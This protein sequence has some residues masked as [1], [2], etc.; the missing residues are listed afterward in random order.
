MA[1]N[2]EL[3]VVV[4][5]DASSAQRAFRTVD[6][7]AGR[8]SN[9]VGGKFKSMALAIGGA[10]AGIQI[11]GFL[12]GAVQEARE[13]EKIGRIT[14]NTI[15]QT[16]G[17]A[18]VTAKDVDKMSEALSNQ[19]GIDDDL[20]QGGANLLLTFKNVRNEVG[21]GNDIFN[22][23]NGLA[24][25]MSVAFGQDLNSS[26]IQLGKALDNPIK[27]V[28]A[29]QRV[30][31]SFTDQQK[32]QIKTLVESGK[33][34]EAQKIILGELESQVGGTAKA[35]A[36]PW[37]KFGVVMGNLKES[38]GKSLLPILSDLATWLGERLPGA[39]ARVQQWFKD[40]KETIKAWGD[41]IGQVISFIANEVIPRLVTAFQ[42][43]FARTQEIIG[44]LQAAWRMFGDDLTRIFQ[45]VFGVIKGVWDFFAGIFTGDWS[46]VW[47]A[48]LGIFQGAWNIVAGAI[49]AAF[50]AIAGI[51]QG[52]WE[53]F[54]G[55]WEGA[56]N[57]IKDIAKKVIDTVSG[58]LTDL[59]DTAKDLLEKLGLI[60]RKKSIEQA[61]KN[62]KP[63]DPTILGPPK[64]GPLPPGGTI[65]AP[66]KKQ[67]ARGGWLFPGDVSLVG[68][69][70]PEIITARR[71]GYVHT[72]AETARMLAGNHMNL[73]D[74]AVRV[75]LIFNGSPDAATVARIR[76][77][78]DA[79][80]TSAFREAGRMQL[81]GVG[82]N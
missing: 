27:G 62:W 34:L 47:N 63:G 6:D 65:T 50:G 16:G 1:G 14:A 30:G 76:R 57:A 75:N 15:K 66:K 52:A 74:G 56:W 80:I 78:V 43:V 77:E 36:D 38:I 82:S 51:F 59:L 39:I 21:K 61:A 9:S 60:E 37:Q 73:A 28:T 25:D 19:I 72:A 5:G 44:F 79:G 11:A 3:K 7:D 48:L 71:S 31:V 2:R 41:A 42:W 13:A 46:R 22:R 55:I 69:E 70:G 24:A 45:G 12:K 26:A 53:V 32:E 81:V 20:I 35:A 33:T 54:K 18:N 17:V 4:L 68:E 29:L 67:N 40:N 8:V 58:W 64:V 23:A 49:G 10:F